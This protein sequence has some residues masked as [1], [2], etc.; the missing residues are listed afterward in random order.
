MSFI[1]SFKKN[2]IR[3]DKY[4]DKYSFLCCFLLLVTVLRIPNFFEPYW[5]GDE[6]IYLTI[7]TAI[8][9]SERLYA[10]IVDH[11]T[12]LIYYLAAVPTQLYFRMLLYIW[13]M[14]S[15]VVFHAISRKLLKSNISHFVS[16]L[17]FNLL[18][19]LPWFEGHIPNGELF[20][21][22]FVLVGTWIGINTPSIKQHLKS[23]TSTKSLP[24]PALTK[25]EI[26]LLFISGLFF[27]LALLTKV[28][29]MFDLAGFLTLLFF[30]TTHQ[31]LPERLTSA[32][33]ME[34]LRFFFSR[35]LIVVLGFITPLIL[36]ILY[37]Y[38]IGAGSAYLD[39]GLLYNFHY[40]GTWKLELATPLLTALFTL[41]AKFLIVVVIFSGLALLTPV[42]TIQFQFIAAWFILSLFASLLSNRPYPHYFLQVAPPLALLIATLFETY[43]PR[44]R[45]KMAALWATI[46]P[47]VSTVLLTSLLIAVLFLLNVRPYASRSYYQTWF[48]YVTNN[49]TKDQ[50]YQSFNYLMADN[51]K[52]A[53][54]IAAAG[55]KHLFIWG[56]N[57]MLYALSQTIP[58]GRFTVSFHIEDLKVHEQTLLDIKREEPTFIVMMH[59]EKNSFP[60]L[61]GYIQK[62][63]LEYNQ[64]ENFTLYIKSSN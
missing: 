6:G 11:K 54:E 22:G 46:T 27:G 47:K 41:G 64:Y 51:Y 55:D 40:S 2:F 21:M 18:T 42:L 61:N 33:I 5:Y 62:E 20:V 44:S 43:L 7:G 17:L 48:K 31:L 56:T 59:N 14:I 37:F 12:P 49:I 15:T 13:M 35:V 57:P 50:Y 53:K 58:A 3:L 36:S 8:R 26:S 4:L 60:E 16:M 38:A 19:T 25:K 23:T 32:S 1:S 10:D 39:F 45:A 30:I 9:Y 34:Q 52:A 63:Y 29:A 24:T 28:P